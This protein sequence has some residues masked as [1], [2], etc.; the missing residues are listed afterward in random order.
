MF[1][2]TDSHSILFP[3]FIFL[4]VYGLCFM[5][6]KSVPRNIEIQLYQ[7]F[8]IVFRQ[9]QNF[10]DSL[11][12][13]LQSENWIWLVITFYVSLF[14][15]YYDKY[16]ITIIIAYARGLKIHPTTKRENLQLKI[17]IFTFHIR[18]LHT[19]EESFI[20]SAYTYTY[21]RNGMHNWDEILYPNLSNLL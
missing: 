15:I 7:Q 17:F 6:I 13:I 16:V 9:F 2:F 11:T 5:W 14:Y 20:S 21:M 10:R 19:Q 3:H 12:K 1:D 18:I 4:I 8:K